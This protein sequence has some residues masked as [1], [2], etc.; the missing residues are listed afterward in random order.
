M[1]AR[2][3]PRQVARG[4]CQ[5]ACIPWETVARTAPLAGIVYDLALLWYADRVQQGHAPAWP[6]RPWY[7]SKTAPSFPDMLTALRQASWR[8]DIAAPPCSPR[9]LRNAAPPRADS[10]CAA[11]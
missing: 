1:A 11:A 10:G 3:S 6:V 5:F 8:R 2:H 4:E 7:R 9:C